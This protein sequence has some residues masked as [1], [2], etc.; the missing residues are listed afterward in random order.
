MTAGWDDSA[1]L[2]WLAE[3]GIELIR[4]MGRI[5]GP[6]RVRVGEEVHETDR[7][8]LAT[9]SKPV[10]PPIPG[11]SWLPGLWTNRDIAA[12]REVPRRLLILGGGAV[13]VEMAQAAA[14][15]GAEVALVEGGPHLLAREPA[16]LGEALAGALRDD[17]VEV[18]VGRHATAARMEGG[19]YVL[20]LA[21]GDELEG[22]RLLVAT[23]RAPRTD[24]IGLE[25]IGLAASPRGVPVDDRLRAADGVWAVGD[26]TGIMLFTHVGK[27]QGRI[28]AAD[29]LGREARADYRA[30]PR[31]V[32]TDPQAAAVGSAEGLSTGTARL[33]QV[34]R[35]YT[36]ERPLRPGF[37]TMVSDGERLVGAYAI[38][39]EAG[40]WLG[41]ATVAIRAGIPLEVLRDTIQPFPTFSEIYVHALD[42]LCGPAGDCLTAVE[43]AAPAGG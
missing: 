18:R 14:R 35:A 29:M 34:P 33:D 38:G 26:V 13:G 1:Q 12:M 25:R 19:R 20:S 30:V 5:D 31:V 4:G 15:L 28:A 24:G 9:G 36:Y 2:P 8:V 16:A 22:D 42:D 6:G 3:K 27:Y 11:L 41:Q 7:I 32:F 39:P 17:G 10:I 37:L 40:E 21:D 43:A 23:G